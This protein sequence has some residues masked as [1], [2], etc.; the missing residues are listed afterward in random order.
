MTLQANTL[1]ALR[2]P[3]LIADIGGTNARFALVSDAHAATQ[4]FGQCPTEAHPGFA[5]AAT[6]MV[7]DKTSL[8][9]RTAV[10]AV[11]G[12]V[13]GD[14]IP[15]TNANWVIEPKRLLEDMNLD[16]V[17]VL[18][19][20]EAQAL[21]L[22]GLEGNDVEAIGGGTAL[23]FGAKVVVGPG[24]GLGAAA[25]VHAHETWVPIPGEGG[26][27][28]LGPVSADDEKIWPFIERQDGRIGA[29][30]IIC[31]AGLLRLARAVARADGAERSYASPAD[32][33]DAA[34]AGDDV[35]LHTME[36]FARALGRVSGDFALTFLARGGVFL[37]GGIAPK[38]DR[39]LKTGAFRASFEAKAPH[40]ALMKTIPTF[41]VRHANPAL[42][43]LASFA[44]TPSL[45]AVEL[46]G[47]KWERDCENRAA[48]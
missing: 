8:L 43:G 26:H 1:R 13:T 28:E 42:E 16:A 30:R 36:V 39:Y 37:A 9:P 7:L 5:E 2:F 35:A 3:V 21:A 47:R 44:R 34:D 31:G 6:A 29:E 19:D 12:P 17:I 33:T 46:N 23:P 48:S 4:V 11:A 45:F 25:M 24:T 15:L 32:V 41:L 18:N 20:F 38:I 27:V 14:R 10:L 40:A 22:P